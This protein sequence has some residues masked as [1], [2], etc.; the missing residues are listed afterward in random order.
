MLRFGKTKVAKKTFMV[1]S[2]Y[3][4]GYLDDS[5][6]PFVQILPKMTGNFKIFQR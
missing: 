5:I 6:R 1:Y 2:E 4:I 3:L